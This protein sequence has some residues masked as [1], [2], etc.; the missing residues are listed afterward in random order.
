[1]K[2]RARKTR[3]DAQAEPYRM[4]EEK[5][6][7]YKKVEEE[8]LSQQTVLKEGEKKPKIPRQI[9]PQQLAESRRKNFKEVPFGYTVEQA[10]REASRCIQCKNPLCF[11][12]CPGKY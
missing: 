4:D 10:Q 11:D 8:L 6:E 5:T 9:M 7:T 2:L 12:G 3:K 1:M